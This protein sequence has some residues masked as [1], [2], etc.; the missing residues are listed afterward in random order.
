MPVKSKVKILQN[1]VTF[2][3]YVNF[4]C[5]NL[6][7][8][9]Q[10][11]GSDCNGMSSELNFDSGFRAMSLTKVRKEID[12]CNFPDWIHEKNWKVIP[13]GGLRSPLTMC[14]EFLCCE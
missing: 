13:R 14:F 2:S 6:Y 4:N 5:P 9:A 3:E 7:T 11:F 1:F 8:V 12:N 10:G